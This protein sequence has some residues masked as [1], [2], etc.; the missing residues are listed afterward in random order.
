MCVLSL[1]CWGSQMPSR[2]LA[3]TRWLHR[4]ALFLCFF[5]KLNELRWV[6]KQK[7]FLQGCVCWF[8]NKMLH[9]NGLHCSGVFANGPQM[10]EVW[11]SWCELASEVSPCC[12]QSISCARSI[13]E[14]LVAALVQLSKGS[15]FMFLPWYF[16]CP[17]ISGSNYQGWDWEHQIELS[18]RS[19]LLW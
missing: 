7:H 10:P 16:P 3:L 8:L 6:D 17:L 4:A 1:C 18:Y 14:C 11:E 12:L 13:S 5:W 15:F 19:P 2:Q 9:E